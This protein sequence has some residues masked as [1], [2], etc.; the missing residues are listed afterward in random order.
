MKT[1]TQRLALIANSRGSMAGSLHHFYQPLLMLF[2]PRVLYVALQ[3]GAFLSWISVI[4]VME[5]DY[6]SEAPYNFTTV[7]I[8]LLDV[9]LFIGAVFAPR[10]FRTIE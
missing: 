8:G 3:F 7:G 4:A 9:L 2:I 5:S 1:N 10:L 6:F